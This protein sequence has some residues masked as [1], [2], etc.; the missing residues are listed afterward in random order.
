MRTWMITVGVLCLFRL[1]AMSA[2][3]KHAPNNLGE[4]SRQ[5][6]EQ[7]EPT[8]IEGDP[9]D[10]VEL[11]KTIELFNSTQG[12]PTHTNAAGEVSP[13]EVQ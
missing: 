10:V 2:E 5:T 3:R 8:I 6:S 12:L 11:V 4:T 7:S 9:A 1:P 13:T